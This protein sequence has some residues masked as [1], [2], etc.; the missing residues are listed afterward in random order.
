MS[1][2]D[3]NSALDVFLR[4][5]ERNGNIPVIGVN[6]KA[7]QMC[8]FRTMRDR[9]VELQAQVEEFNESGAGLFKMRKDP[10]VTPVGRALLTVMSSQLATALF[11][12]WVSEGLGMTF[13]EFEEPVDFFHK[14]IMG[15][16]LV[17]LL[18]VGHAAAALHHHLV[19]KDRTLIKMTRGK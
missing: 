13:K 19:Y 8:K 18:I 2:P 7:F 4:N 11:T 3:A 1:F 5:Q 12:A 14:Q 10:R 15:A 6:R 16:W 17:W 9:A